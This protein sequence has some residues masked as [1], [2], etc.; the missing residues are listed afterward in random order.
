MPDALG[1]AAALAFL[2]LCF[3]TL[4][5]ELGILRRTPAPIALACLTLTLFSLSCAFSPR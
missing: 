2:A 5:E 1:F 4:G 3:T